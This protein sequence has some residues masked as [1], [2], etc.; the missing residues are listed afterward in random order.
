[1]VKLTSDIIN[2]S[3]RVYIPLTLMI[4]FDSQMIYRLF[5]LSRSSQAVQKNSLMRKE[6]QFTI[7]AISCDVYFFLCYFPLSLLNFWYYVNFFSGVFSNNSTLST[8]G[9]FYLNICL[10]FAFLFQTC[11]IFMYFGFNKLFRKDL[12]KII[13]CILSCKNS[14]S[15]NM[16]TND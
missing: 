1:M 12:I 10:N 9:V 2:I 14:R 13:S 3:L 4:V 8:L 6:H 15:L 11:S 7:A 5:K 16:E